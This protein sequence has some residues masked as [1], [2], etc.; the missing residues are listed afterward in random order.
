[1]NDLALFAGVG[2]GILGGRLLGWRTICAVEINDYARRVLVARQEDGCLEPFPIWDDICTFDGRPWA[3]VADIITGGFPCQDISSAGKRAGITGER[4]GLWKEFAR[5]IGEVR[6]RY[7]FIENSSHLRTRGLNVVLRDLAGL[8]YNAR[9][10]VVGAEASGAPHLRKRMWILAADAYHDRER[11][12]AIDEKM[13]ETPPV[14]NRI[15]GLPWWEQPS[16]STRVDDGMAH[17]MDRIRATGNGQVAP[18]VPLVWRLLGGY[19]C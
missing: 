13:A 19:Q 12:L 5:V 6:P 16:A 1:M 2:G 3:G 10:G 4:S 8:G 11:V 9:W 15:C 14:A 18:V 7:A 17:R